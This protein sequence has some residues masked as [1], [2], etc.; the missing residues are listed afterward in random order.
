MVKYLR[1]F[2]MANNQEATVEEIWLDGSNG[3]KVGFFLKA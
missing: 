1:L 3:G 2:S